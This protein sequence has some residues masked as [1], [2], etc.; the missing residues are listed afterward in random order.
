M[1]FQ[2]CSK[3]PLVKLKIRPNLLHLKTSFCN[4]QTDNFRQRWMRIKLKKMKRIE[5]SQDG[6]VRRTWKKQSTE[7]AILK[8][9]QVGVNYN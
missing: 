6:A 9:G 1:D 2:T 4:C 7:I 5:V 8:T 3:T